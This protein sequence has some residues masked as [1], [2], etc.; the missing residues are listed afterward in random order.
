MFQTRG[1]LVVAR[2]DDASGDP[3]AGRARQECCRSGDRCGPTDRG[4]L[5]R[6]ASHDSAPARAERRPRASN[7]SCPEEISERFLPRA[8]AVAIG[9]AFA[10]RPVLATAA[11]L[12]FVRAGSG[13]DAWTLEAI[14]VELPASGAVLDWNRV[15]ACA[16]EG[17]DAWLELP[18]AE[19]AREVLTPS[20][21][22]A[23]SFARWRRELVEHLYRTRTRE[24]W[25]C[26]TE[27]LT[28]ENGE[29]Q[30]AFLVRCRDAQ[31]AR[32]DEAI[33][34]LRKK[35]APRLAALAER[36]RQAD[37]RVERQAEEYRDKRTSTWLGAGASRRA[38]R[39]LDRGGRAARERGRSL[40]F[41][42]EERAH[43]HR[44]RRARSRSREIAA[45]RSRGRRRARDRRRASSLRGRRPAPRCHRD[46]TAQERHPA[47]AARPAE[48]AVALRSGR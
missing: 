4:V 10:Y 38:L 45:R 37:Q 6:R 47:R 25:V 39:T 48:E 7:G 22:S 29:S 24:Q 31:H 12:H 11:R 35:Y 46:P 13:M 34:K 41:E 33:E 2:T 40:G 15:E 36:A 27:G 16:N 21:G 28:S 14:T 5:R 43:R 26:K 42:R 19:L 8:R 20:A 18:E 30:G 3:T 17:R 32:R 23:K 44:A 9:A 1:A